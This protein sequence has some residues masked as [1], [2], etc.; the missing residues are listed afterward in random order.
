MS[1][2]RRI[3]R[4]IAV[5][6]LALGFGPR[7]LAFHSGGVGECEGCHSM[8]NSYENAAN[9]TGTPQ[10]RSGPWLLRARDQSSTCLNCHDGVTTRFSYHVATAN[11][12]P[13]DA[14]TPV[15]MTPGG[16]FA[17]L[18]KTMSGTVR[19]A[20]ATWEGD[21]HGHN[22]VAVD[23]GYT[24]DKVLT[25]APGG[26]YPASNLHC[27]S[28]HDPHGRFRRFADGS[29]ARTGLPIAG[30]G[31]Y[32]DSLD[33]IAGVIAVGTYRKLAGVGFQ[34]MSLP[35][36]YAFTN[37]PPDA[38]AP[39]DFNHPEAPT[40]LLVAY[41]TGMSEWCANCHPAMHRD[42]YTSGVA[43]L[44]HPAGSG[45]KLTAAVVASYNAYVSSGVMTGSGASYSTLAPFE[46]GTADRVVLKQFASGAAPSYAAATTDNVLCLSCHRA[47]ASA[48]ES[49]TRYSL[50]NE[51]M[52]IA[53]AADAA[54]YDPST[55]ENAINLGYTVEQQQNAYYGRPA[56]AFGPYA[57]NYCNK[58]HAKD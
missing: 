47:H 2:H 21:R 37:G 54:A 46:L 30:S 9:V 42:A 25:L 56:S 58:C 28:C 15:Q 43:G 10:Y 12:T 35:G 19:Q 50:S 22:I 27:S 55:T 4:G 24:V 16:D 17:W 1:I 39:A 51:F 49:M 13:Y 52:T 6:A 57:R 7:A 29:V 32:T 3:S 45:A 5:L 26:T 23:Y 31:S 20:A 48:F 34:P 14:T 18:K 53:D 40:P 41:G 38:V 8:H 11:V 36:P 44:S 33:P